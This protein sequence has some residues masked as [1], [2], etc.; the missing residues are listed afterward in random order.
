[1]NARHPVSRREWLGRLAAAGAALKFAEPHAPAQTNPSGAVNRNSAPSALRITDMRACRIAG[2]LD[3]P[4]IRIDTNQGVYGLGEVRD[5]GV[6][7]I[8][9]VLKPH[10]LG[11][12]PLDIEPVLDNIRKF[13]NH[14]RGAGGYSAVDTALHDIAGKVYGVPCWR[15][16]GSRYRSKVRIYCHFPSSNDPAK[17]A[18]GVRRRKE[19]GFT[20]Y[21]MDD[22]SAARLLNK[23]PGAVQDNG[24]PTD[25]GIKLMC[26]RI[27]QV[28]EIIGWEAPL[29]ADHFG[30]LDVKE[31]IRL[32]RAFEPYRLA[33]MEDILQVGTLRTGDAP[34]NWQAYKEIRQATLTPLAMGESLFGLPEGFREFIDNR[35]IDIVHPDLLTAGGIRE[36][37]R[38][39]DYAS[40]NGIPTACHYVASP[41]GCLATVHTIATMKDFV[42]METMAPDTTWWDDMVTG[43]PKPLIQN[44]YIQV[45]D[46]PGLGIELNDD[47]VKEHLR[48]PGYFEPTPQYD[49][50]IIDDYRSG[51]APRR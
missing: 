5:A 41:V 7:G 21:K 8:G 32:A 25:K 28:R 31:S 38:I 37:K 39:A 43:L 9:L 6:E 20:F 29:A 19:Q 44:G 45:P 30:A 23:V 50:Y 35:A 16:L 48:V 22:L 24:V 14:M 12:N 27:A 1:M 15:L 13:S 4:I 3:F 11:R 49:R 46:R 51:T 33:W 10:L 34:S 2:V 40:M 47:V 36:T 18:E 26:E 17:Y 42:A